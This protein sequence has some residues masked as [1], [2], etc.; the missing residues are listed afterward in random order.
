[1]R[2]GHRGSLRT[3]RFPLL[4]RALERHM[5]WAFDHAEVGEVDLAAAVLL[6]VR[7]VA[8]E[9]SEPADG[10]ECSIL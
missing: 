10:P 5:C 7:A 2:P 3:A 8:S 4:A 9:I 1:M 6:D